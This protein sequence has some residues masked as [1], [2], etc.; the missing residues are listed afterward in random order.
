M[1]DSFGLAFF[2]YLSDNIGAGSNTLFTHVIEL[3]FKRAVSS[4]TMRP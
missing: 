4:P 2:Q 1:N 3:T